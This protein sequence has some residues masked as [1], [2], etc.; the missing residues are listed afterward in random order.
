MNLIEQATQAFNEQFGYAPTH[1][2]Y[3]PGRVNLI[4]EHTDY[5]DGFV[6]PAAINFGT[7]VVA[8]KRDDTKIRVCAANFNKQVVV[9]DLT[10]PLE[11]DLE[12]PWSNYVRGVC[13]QLLQNEYSLMGADLTISGDVPYGAGLSSSAALEVVLIR[14]FVALSGGTIDATFAAQLGQRTENEFIG[15]QTGIMDQLIIAKGEADTALLIDCRDLST[16]AVPLDPEFKIVIFNSN[17]KRGLVDSEYN[18]RR[19]QCQT[20]SDV[21]GISHLRDADLAMLHEHEGKMDH[22]TFKRARHVITEN[23]R[24]VEAADALQHRNWERLSDLMAQSHVSMKDDF[25][26]TVPPIDGIVELVSE[27]IGLGNGGVRMT[28]GGFGG[29][30]VAL[31]RNHR[32]DDVISHVHAHYQARYG[33]QETVYICHSVPGAFMRD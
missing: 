19:Q 25:E 28:G 29:C 18:L 26:I 15:A 13:S 8:A 16:R 32:V 1:D 2:F 30:V 11:T 14:A 31:V 24:T 4:G 22:V 20:A 6:L 23:T 33:I 10:R 27:S 12:F 3:A 5:N 7:A 9:F 21:M 17:V